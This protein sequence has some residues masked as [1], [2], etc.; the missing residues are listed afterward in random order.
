MIAIGL[1]DRRKQPN[2]SVRISR[3]SDNL[4]FAIDAVI[5]SRHDRSI[6]DQ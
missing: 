3:F 4:G 6:A 2:R 1:R 5:P